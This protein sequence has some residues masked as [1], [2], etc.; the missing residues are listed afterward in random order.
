MMLQTIQA[1]FS[2]KLDHLPSGFLSVLIKRG[3]KAFTCLLSHR[4]QIVLKAFVQLK[5]TGEK[6]FLTRLFCPLYCSLTASLYL[7]PA[8]FRSTAYKSKAYFV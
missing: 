3:G 1:T 5:K 4:L 2:K 6:K 8:F 7:C